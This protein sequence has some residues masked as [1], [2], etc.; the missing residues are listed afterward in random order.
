MFQGR[1]EFWQPPG[2]FTGWAYDEACP[3]LPLPVAVLGPTGA[4][5]ASGIAHLCREDLVA[6]RRG[7]GWCGFRLRAQAPL[8][9]GDSGP[10]Y[11]VA[12]KARRVIHD[13]DAPIPVAAAGPPASGLED[14]FALEALWQLEACGDLLE[15]FVRE[16]GAEVFVRRAHIYALGRF[17]EAAEAERGAR[18]LETATT[19]PLALLLALARRGEAEASL[20]PLAAP[21]SSAFPFV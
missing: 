7:A 19:T 11:L 2:V 8:S 14:A 18:A 9:P 6:Q 12:T 1:L 5:L 13:L 17:A 10:L 4:E 15:A 21:N 20:R 16:R 3:A